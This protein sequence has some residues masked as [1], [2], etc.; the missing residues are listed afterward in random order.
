MLLVSYEFGLFLILLTVVYYLL[1]GRFQ[2]ILLLAASCLFYLCGGPLYILYPLITTIT[3]WMLAR[4]MGR[5]SADARQY[6]KAQ[7]FDREQKK[8]YNR[9][10]KS[11]RKRL[12]LLGLFLNFGILAVLKYANFALQ[13]VNGLLHLFHSPLEF[14]YVGWLLPLGISYYTFQS[15]GYLIDVYN[16]KYEPEQNPARFALFVSFFPQLVAG[17]ISRFDQIKEDLFAPHAFD[18]RRLKI[19]A[20]RMLW[21]YFKKLVI[22]DRLGPAVTAI[23]S[24]PSE[25]NGIYVLLGMVGYTV[26]MYADFAGGI[27]IVIG[28]AQILGVK[29][30]ENFDRPF[31]SASLAEFWR[32]WHMSL[33]QWLREYIFFP[34]STSRFS[35][36]VSAVTGKL[37]GRKAG[38][39]APVYIA[40]IV[41]WLTAGIWHGA[42]WNFVAWGMANCIVML[43][44][45]ELSGVYRSFRKR[46]AFTGSRGY[47]WFGI[48]RT[49]FLFCCLEMFEYY[50]FL[51][52]FTMFGNMLT[53]SSL[54]QLAD[55]RM[56][57]LGLGGMD[58]ILLLVGVAVMA[59]GAV[60]Q[61]KDGYR[62]W[63]D[64]KPVWLQYA[65]VFGLFLVVLL[66]GAYGQ[67]YDASQFIYNQF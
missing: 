60:F 4:R 14:N 12:L 11:R 2:W 21:G 58:W 59:L 64:R 48:V 25:Y 5:I 36:K 24:S 49:F 52:V 29:L 35:K 27:D 20:E 44:S 15:M 6:V 31:M 66:T 10:V 54:L 65:A 39:K 23:I 18:A 40:N 1:P 30:P 38:Q 26:W 17:P 8:A 56:T 34:V 42:S 28:V 32:R 62:E 7:G 57:S 37:L 33:M 55:G 61:K 13:N 47:H 50:P 63:L 43:V 19:G 67:G 41:V 3:T 46:F 16:S 53:S 51:T 45:A 22:A 9:T